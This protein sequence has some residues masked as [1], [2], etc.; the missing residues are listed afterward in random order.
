MHAQEW[1]AFLGLAM[2]FSCFDMLVAGQ[3]GGNN[4][5][6]QQLQKVE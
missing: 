3:H 1:M 5:L 4:G 6:V 2:Y